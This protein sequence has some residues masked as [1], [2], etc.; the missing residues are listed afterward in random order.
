MRGDFILHTLDFSVYPEFSIEKGKF[1]FVGGIGPY[2]GS[3]LGSKIDG[4]MAQTVEWPF[5]TDSIEGPI[6]GSAEDYFLKKDVGFETVLGA[7][8]AVTE[9]IKILLETNLKSLTCNVL[10]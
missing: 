4:V 9:R 10:N 8:F 6:T 1:T 7:E 2:F 5:S 3:V